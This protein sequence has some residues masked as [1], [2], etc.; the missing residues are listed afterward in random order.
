MRSTPERW[1]LGRRHLYLL[2]GYSAAL[3]PSS[4]AEFVASQT[5]ALGW[6]RKIEAGATRLIFPSKHAFTACAFGS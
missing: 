4:K 6:H 2:S 5:V 1:S 3:D